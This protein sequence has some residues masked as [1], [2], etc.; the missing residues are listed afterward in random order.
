MTGGAAI[1]L[2]DAA[3]LRQAHADG[4][5]DVPPGYGLLT[6]AVIRNRGDMVDVLLDLGL[7]PDDRRRLENLDEDVW[8]WGEPLRECAI[9]D[10]LEIAA[11]LLERGADPN[12]SI[13]A[14]T[15]PMFEAWQRR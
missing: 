8:S 12:P 7:D 1:A 11:L 10:R 3:W 2:G 4:L 9:H 15:S 13:Y 5:L 14:A 6:R